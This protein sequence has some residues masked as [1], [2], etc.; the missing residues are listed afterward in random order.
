MCTVDIVP[1]KLVMDLVVTDKTVT[2]KTVTD[3]IVTDK[4][5][6]DALFQKSWR[7]LRSRLRRRQNQFCPLVFLCSCFK[8][9]LMGYETFEP[10][11][12]N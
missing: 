2:D 8:T 10:R 5:V 12:S 9:S 4:K 6:K 1:G 11:D 3:K 7:I